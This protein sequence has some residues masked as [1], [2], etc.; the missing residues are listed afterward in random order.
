MGVLNVTPD[1][2]SDGGRYSDLPVALDHASKLI[3]AG[4]S[5]LDVG[6]ESTRPGAEAVSLSDELNRVIPVVDALHQQFPEV[7]ISIDTSKPQVMRAAMDAGAQLINDVAAL[8]GDGALDAVVECSAGVCLMHMQGQPRTM[9]QNPAYTDVVGEVLQFLQQRIDACMDIGIDRHRIAID[10]GFGFG[11]SLNHNL[12]L[13][14]QLHR[15]TE[16]NVP[17]LVGLSR[18][19]MIGQILDQPVETRL[20]GSVTAAL[21]AVQNGAN[22]IR[23]HDV[24]ETRDALRLWR[25]VTMEHA[26]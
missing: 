9:Q 2:F 8:Q 21:I 24:A 22:I 6:G 14:R 26:C 4:A 18:K 16:L 12:T 20:I 17:V 11:K 5:I 19:S 7:V 25:A 13:L 1:S 15:F 10:P 23:V 3:E